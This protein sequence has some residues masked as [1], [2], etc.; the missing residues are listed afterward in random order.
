M[1]NLLS[2]GTPLGPLLSLSCCSSSA[3]HKDQLTLVSE[4]PAPPRTQILPVQCQSKVSPSDP[5]CPSRILTIP[6]CSS[7][8]RITFIRPRVYPSVHLYPCIYPYTHTHLSPFIHQ[9]THLFINTD[10]SLTIYPCIHTNIHTNL[11]LSIHPSIPAMS[12][13]LV[14][15]GHLM[16]SPTQT[17]ATIYL[18]CRKIT[19]R[20]LFLNF[21]KTQRELS[22]AFV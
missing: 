9:F 15:L 6:H 13:Q 8:L 21:C 3:I 14:P 7:L 4:N 5:F 18:F 10:I 1:N 17:K 12:V 19:N 2:L 22:S 20:K 11:S 16:W